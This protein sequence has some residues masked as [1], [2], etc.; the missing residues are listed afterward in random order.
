MYE[1][2]LCSTRALIRPESSSYCHGFA[3]SP[4]LSIHLAIFVL[5][6]ITTSLP[7]PRSKPVNWRK[8]PSKMV[9]QHPHH[10]LI[11]TPSTSLNNLS[12]IAV[13]IHYYGSYTNFNSTVIDKNASHPKSS[14]NDF[15]H[16]NILIF[17]NFIGLI[18]KSIDFSNKIFEI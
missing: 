12:I 11:Y 17:K 15:S 6:Q 8:I 16:I 4:K 3:F 18:L 5:W 10:P 13:R 1:T 14:Y 2:R 7:W 9:F